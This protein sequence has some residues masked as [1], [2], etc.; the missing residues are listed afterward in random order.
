MRLRVVPAA[1]LLR[2]SLVL[3]VSAVIAGVLAGVLS[4]GVMRVASLIDAAPGV[5]GFTWDGSL[6]LIRDVVLLYSAPAALLFV[7]A[8]RLLPGSW[9]LKGVLFGGLPF[10]V[11]LV[12]QLGPE[13]LLVKF[14][15]A[16][17]CIVYGV[18]LAFLVTELEGRARRW[19]RLS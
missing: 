8:R 19:I 11:F 12:A 10:L 14:L 18:T 9:L 2:T 4:R 3:A 16:L 5:Q 1:H 6:R 17:V 13:V 15:F 7:V